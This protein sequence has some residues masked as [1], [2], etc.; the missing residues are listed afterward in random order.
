MI[1]RYDMSQFHTHAYDCADLGDA[2]KPHADV[3]HILRFWDFHKSLYLY[4]LLGG[5]LIINKTFTYN[6]TANQLG[7]DMRMMCSHHTGFIGNFLHNL[8]TVLKP[9]WG[10]GRPDKNAIF[11]DTV[12]NMLNTINLIEGRVPNNASAVVMGKEIQLTAGQKSMRALGRI[13]SLLNMDEDFEK[14]RIAHSQVLNQ[15]TV[16]GEL[17][18]SIH[19]L[20]FATA[21]DNHNGWSSCMSWE[22]RGCYRLGTVEMMNSP[23]V[24]CAYMTGKNVMGGVGGGEW[25]SKKWRAWVIVHKDII[26]VNRQ[27]PYHNDDIAAAVVDWIKELA[28]S[29]LNWDYQETDTD[30]NFSDL[31][32][33]FECDHMYNDVGCENHAGAYG[34]H[35]AQAYAHRQ[36]NFSG[37]AVC[38]CC[39]SEI[40]YYGDD[41]GANTLCCESC[42]DSI[43]CCCCGQEMDPEEVSWANNGQAYCYDCYNENFSHCETCGDEVDNEDATFLE[44]GVDGDLLESLIRA[45][46]PDSAIYNWNR[47]HWGFNRGELAPMPESLSN[48][49]CNRCLMSNGID[50]DEDILYDI[51]MPFEHYKCINYMNRSSS[52][53]YVSAALN[54]LTVGYG[55]FV[56]VFSPYP[57][58]ADTDG[59]FER[60][61]RKVW[62]DYT[63]RLIDHGIIEV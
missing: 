15:R 46:G 27:Y 11:Y 3:E 13:A 21:S 57:T 62:A 1:E 32:F 34:A 43:R 19:P 52:Y 7:D 40:P 23:M 58:Y 9:K 18:L 59:S 36:L 24:L 26:L 22:S 61:W 2:C 55:Q 41:D 10:M 56:Q 47:N 42:R 37:P 17:H 51:Q 48:T 33:Q 4:D 25:N 16:Q 53:S 50:R 5:E 28:K 38:M 12:C 6:R 31:G 30:L 60:V 54:P 44:M 39:G 14:F 35:I 8:E 63:R 29:N 45:E 49:L 20:D